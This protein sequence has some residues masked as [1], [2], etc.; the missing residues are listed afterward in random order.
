MQVGNLRNVWKGWAVLVAVYV[1]SGLCEENFEYRDDFHRY[2]VKYPATWPIDTR[3]RERFKITNYPPR[4]A[5]RGGF[6][7]PGGAWIDLGPKP[8]WLRKKTFDEWVT[9]RLSL[10][11]S[12]L[13]RDQGETFSER[14]LAL[15][16]GCT[17]IRTTMKFGPDYWEEAFGCYFQSQSQDF[18]AALAYKK[19]EPNAREFYRVYENFL[20]SFRRF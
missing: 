3:S 1:S 10:L 15:G 4:A 14:R 6:P 7:P 2:S 8:E 5:R 12:G 11:D 20:R 19:G 18:S 16:P 13:D 17:E 9:Y